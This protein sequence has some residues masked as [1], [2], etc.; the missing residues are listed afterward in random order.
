MTHYSEHLTLKPNKELFIE[1]VLWQCI[2]SVG[3]DILESDAGS[4]FE[5]ANGGHEIQ[6]ML[7]K[8]GSALGLVPF[9]G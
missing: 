5:D 6:A 9:E 2:V 8:V 1:T 7:G 4:A 3:L